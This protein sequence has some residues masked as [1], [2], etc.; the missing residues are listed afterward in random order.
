[1]GTMVY[2]L[3]WVMQDLYHQPY[4]LVGAVQ[5][6]ARRQPLARVVLEGTSIASERLF[7]PYWFR[8]LGV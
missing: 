7:Q 4:V 5:V 6:D 1:M 3:L 8:G 2:S